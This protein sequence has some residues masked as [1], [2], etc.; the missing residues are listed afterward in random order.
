MAVG[1]GCNGTFIILDAAGIERKIDGHSLMTLTTPMTEEPM[2]T[3]PT[4]HVQ[5]TSAKT[6]F[7]YV[8]R[9]RRGVVQRVCGVC[10][11]TARIIRK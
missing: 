8:I 1:T 6:A 2:A 9:P 7:R 5:F 3:T 4:I 10:G 11:W